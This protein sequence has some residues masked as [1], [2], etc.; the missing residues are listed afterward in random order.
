MAEQVAQAAQAAQA[1]VEGLGAV[2]VRIAIAA[3]ARSVDHRTSEC[4][5]W[6][7]VERLASQG[8]PSWTT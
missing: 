6:Q 4:R 7:V 3:V 1:V 2:V 5:A 8:R